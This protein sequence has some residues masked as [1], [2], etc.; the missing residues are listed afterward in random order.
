L[1]PRGPRVALVLR[2]NMSSNAGGLCK[3]IHVTTRRWKSASCR[4]I[5]RRSLLKNSW[6]SLFSVFLSIFY[7]A[8]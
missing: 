2:R 1:G 6:K 7:R 3:A 5:E 4:S 8:A